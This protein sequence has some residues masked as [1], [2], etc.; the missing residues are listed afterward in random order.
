MIFVLAVPLFLVAPRSGAAMLTRSGGALTNFIG[1]SENVTLG[2][3]G[4]LKRDNAVVMHVRFEDAQPRDG[5][6]WRGVAL[7]EFTGR[8]WRK[9]AEARRTQSS[10]E[11]DKGFFQLGTTEAL[12]RLTTQTVFLEPIES[13][14]LFAASRPV[15]IQGDFPFVR[16]D[17]EGRCRRAGTNLNE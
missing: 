13:P 14:V 10:K 6:R 15:A 8:G 3:I 12:H 2:E 16:V 4:D 1:F 17:A 11:N 5:F 7:D 9:S